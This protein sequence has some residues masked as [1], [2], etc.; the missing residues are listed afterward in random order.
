M[1]EARSGRAGDQDSL[2]GAI[3]NGVAQENGRSSAANLDSNGSALHFHVPEFHWRIDQH[4]TFVGHALGLA[5]SFRAGGFHAEADQSRILN[6][7]GANDWFGTF[8]GGQQDGFAQF[9]ALE[10]DA[11]FEA[12]RATVLARIDN[13]RIP[14]TRVGKRIGNGLELA[15]GPYRQGAGRDYGRRRPPVAAREP[16]RRGRY[17]QAEKEHENAS[18]PSV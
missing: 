15:T 2:T 14:G 6:G 16:G 7:V 17:Q 3:V 11:A 13:H 18:R 4:D 8:D 5:G 1:R 12:E 9:T 10:G